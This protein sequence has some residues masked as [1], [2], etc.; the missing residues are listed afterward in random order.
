MKMMFGFLYALTTLNKITKTIILSIMC[1]LKLTGHEVIIIK[2][3]DQAKQ[4]KITIQYSSSDLIYFF[5][6]SFLFNIRILFQCYIMHSK[7]K[8]CTP[9][10]YR[11][12]MQRIQNSIN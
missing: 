10:V 1:E 11:L 7:I 2:R 3:Y 8:Q 12:I 5:I 4:E 9:D 6:F